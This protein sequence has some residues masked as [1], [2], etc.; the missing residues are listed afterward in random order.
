MSR[1]NLNAFSLLTLVLLSTDAL[2]QGTSPRACAVD[3]HVPAALGG[4][5]DATL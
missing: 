2:G 5:L 4:A 1:S 3:S